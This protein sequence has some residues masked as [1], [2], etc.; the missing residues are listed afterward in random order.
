MLKRLRAIVRLADSTKSLAA[1][2]AP[3]DREP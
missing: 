3:A 2:T 1:M